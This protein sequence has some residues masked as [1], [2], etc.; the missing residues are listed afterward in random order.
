MERLALKTQSTRKK[1]TDGEREGDHWY[2]DKSDGGA[3]E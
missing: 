2:G 3:A 1:L